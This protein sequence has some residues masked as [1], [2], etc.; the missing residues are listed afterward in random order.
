MRAKHYS[1]L[2]VGLLALGFLVGNSLMPWGPT[3]A[4]AAGEP[5]VQITLLSGPERS[6]HSADPIDPAITY[7]VQVDFLEGSSACV[8]PPPPVD[9]LTLTV[10]VREQLDGAVGGTWPVDTSSWSW[11]TEETQVTGQVTI[12]GASS[13]QNRSLYGIHVCISNGAEGCGTK[14]VRMEHPVSGFTAG[15]YTTKGKSFAQTGSGC[16]LIPSI[17]LPLINEQMAA[18]EFLTIV[19]SGTQIIAGGA[20]AEFLGIPLIGSITMPASLDTPGNNVVLEEVSV[21]GI[22]LSGI[23][24]PGTNCEISGSADGSLMGE[25][26]PGQ[27]LDGS[28][29][30]Y[31]MTLTLGGGTG[32]CDLVAH[33]NCELNISFD[34]NPP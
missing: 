30:V 6:T 25:V 18:T 10:T 1:V 29:R 16:E 11:N 17:A 34:G 2:T 19:P 13:G 12:G 22:D 24:F 32:S 23:G 3:E 9:P 8:G 5:I 33:P 28:I 31:D 7:D 15:L 26:S 27:D 4:Q 14:T 21:S 20:E